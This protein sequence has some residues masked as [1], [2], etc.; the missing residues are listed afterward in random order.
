MEAGDS[1]GSTTKASSVD[2]GTYVV[3]EVQF[4]LPLHEAELNQAV[5]AAL[6]HQGK[7][8]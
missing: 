2:K 7:D 8:G 1:V 6:L 5:M 3:H 4:G